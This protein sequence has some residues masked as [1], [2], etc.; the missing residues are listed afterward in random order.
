MKPK[1]DFTTIGEQI[2]ASLRKAADDMVTEAENLKN[3]VEVLAHGI[4]DQLEEH[5]KLLN[6]M[7]D[8]MRAFGADVVEAHKKLLN[9]EKHE[10]PNP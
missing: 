5:A 3:S 2:I 1:H 10:N 4:A 9:G 6:S 8:R 7:D